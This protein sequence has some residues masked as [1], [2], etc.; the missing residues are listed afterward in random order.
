LL[1][2]K[3]EHLKQ[4]DMIIAEKNRLISHKDEK[5]QKKCLLCVEKN[6]QLKLKDAIIAEKD[7]ALIRKDKELREKDL[8]LM[9]K[10]EQLGQKDM[11]IAEKDRLILPKNEKF[12]EEI[13]MIGEWSVRLKQKEDELKQKDLQLLDMKEQL[14]H[15]N[16]QL[17]KISN[18]WTYCIGKIL[19]FP[20]K[21]VKRLILKL[22]YAG[23]K[24]TLSHHSAGTVVNDTGDYNKK[25]NL[26][27]QFTADFGRHRSGLKYGLYYLKKLHNPRG[28]VFDAFIERTFCWGP[29]GTKPHLSPWIGIIHVPPG[30]PTWF[31]Y[32][33]SNEM[34]FKSDTWGKSLPYCKGLFTMSEYHRKHLETRLEIPVNALFLPTE[35]PGEKWT[36]DKFT[37]NKEKKLIQVGWWLRK[38]HAIYQLP[39]N[40]Y[41]KIFLNIGH[42]SLPRL[43][44]MEREILIKEGTFDNSMYDAVET[45]NFL[46]NRDY[47][48]LLCENI[49][50]IYLYDASANNIIVECIARGTP[51]LVN[52]IEPVKEYLGDDYPLYYNSLEEA[53]G[54]AM[55]LDLIYKTHLFL[56][57]HPIKMKLSGEY[58]LE[59]FVKSGI[60]KGL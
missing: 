39:G 47:D 48:K 41:K 19:V 10:D 8:L 36:W 57:D 43:M 14:S 40:G 5:I 2:L 50:F 52:P 31:N 24:S 4:K 53:A 45:V 59:S 44:E 35:F 1:L 21:V 29:K 20:V 32:H 13:L 28:V 25:I 38:L 56:K 34:I 30:I 23:K 22:K 15:V 42:K 55:D 58:F 37:A 27:S 3:D 17:Q 54:K 18:S 51:L 7:Q 12:K 33:L 9:R 26:S 49:V 6:K 16:R 11:I 60:Y 46:S